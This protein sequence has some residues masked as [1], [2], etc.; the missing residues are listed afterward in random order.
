LPGDE[1]RGVPVAGGEVRELEAGP[2]PA[3]SG[4]LVV[5]Y[6]NQLRGDDGLGPAAAALLAEDPKLHGTRV[7][8]RHQLTPELAAD[9]AEMK[10]VILID[11]NVED[12]AGAVS[13]RRVDGTPGPGSGSGSSHHASPADLAALAGELWGASPAVFVVSVGAASLEVGEGL[14]APV[15]KALPAVVEA[16]IAIMAEHGGAGSTG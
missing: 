5:G 13:V 1:A 10:L 7:L 6:G 2:N 14:S 12:E 4:V 9:F 11:A 3:G 8:A 16:V 15:R